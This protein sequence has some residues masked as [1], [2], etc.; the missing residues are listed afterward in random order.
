MRKG[1][2]YQTESTF[3]YCLSGCYTYKKYK[4]KGVHLLK[5]GIRMSNP[6]IYV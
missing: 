4:V 5:E 1:L 2:M 6:L 3:P